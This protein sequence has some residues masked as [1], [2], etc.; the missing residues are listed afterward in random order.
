MTN[1]RFYCDFNHIVNSIVNFESIVRHLLSWLRHLVV[2]RRWLSCLM[3]VLSRCFLHILL[4]DLLILQLVLLSLFCNHSFILLMWVYSQRILCLFFLLFS[5]WRSMTCRRHSTS[6]WLVII[7]LLRI[8]LT[9]TSSSR[10]CPLMIWSLV[11]I[12]AW[13]SSI[14][15]SLFSVNFFSSFSCIRVFSRCRSNSQ[16]MIHLHTGILQYWSI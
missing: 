8:S 16:V 14:L 12:F 6:S 4:L 9:T 2:G 7:V 13:I 1:Y 3:R 11:N 5:I 10:W 15:S